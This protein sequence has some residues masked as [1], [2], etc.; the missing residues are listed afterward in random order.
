MGVLELLLVALLLVIS[1][2]SS[3]FLRLSIYVFSLPTAEEDIP[4]WCWCVISGRG[5]DGFAVEI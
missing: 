1:P 2:F 3:F 5:D 4:T